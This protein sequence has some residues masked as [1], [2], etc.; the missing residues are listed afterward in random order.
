MRQSSALLL[1]A[2]LS[3]AAAVL[4]AAAAFLLGGQLGGWQWL[5]Y[6]GA[7]VAIF[8]GFYPIRH[9]TWGS[10]RWMRSLLLRQLF[11]GDPAG[12][13]TD[14]P[15]LPGELAAMFEERLRQV[16][17]R[18]RELADRL[19][20]YQQWFEFP[21]PLNLAEVRPA[22]PQTLLRDRALD[23]LLEQKTQL[24]YE[25]I[26]KNEYSLEGTFQFT[27]VRDDVYNLV[28][29]IA[30]LYGNDPRQLLTGVSSERV[31]RAAGRCCVKF[32]VELDKLPLDI[33]TYDVVDVYTYIRRA[34]KVYGLYQSARPYMPWFRSAYYG[35]WLAMGS[36][37]LTM[38][39]WWF[40][41]SLSTRGATTLATNIAN[42]WALNFLHD[43]VRVI[44][45]EVAAIYDR[46]LRYRDPNW[47]FAAELTELVQ[48]FP[49]SEKSLR[50]ALSLVGALQFRNEYDRIFF[51][52]CIVEGK[53]PGLN[54]A[55]AADLLPTQ[56]REI[57]ERLEAFLESYVTAASPKMVQRWRA[58][59]E[60]RLDM[61]L[62]R[63]ESATAGS[64]NQQRRDL[65]RSLAGYL[66]EIKQVEQEAMRPLLERS[67]LVLTMPQPELSDLWQS[68]Q[69]APP[70]FFQT[71]SIVPAE[72]VLRAFVKDLVDLAVS[73]TPRYAVA[74]E[75]VVSTVV[76]LGGDPHTV[77]RLLDGRYVGQL[78]SLLPKDTPNL[79]LP[80]E[81]ARAALDLVQ[82]SEPLRFV[83]GDV[84]PVEVEQSELAGIDRTGTWLVGVGDRL[85]T[86]TL[87]DTPVLLWEGDRRVSVELI[88]GRVRGG[89]HI[90]GGRWLNDEIPSTPVLFLK[91]PFLTSMRRYFAPLQQFC[92]ARSQQPQPGF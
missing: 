51:L 3:I 63:A 86:F 65:I 54:R 30:A 88:K 62:T 4:V 38:G 17:R 52:R 90:S 74:D 47:C 14:L 29:E 58:G 9:A 91:S 40:V 69:D 7:L 55:Q 79:R 28:G 18:E 57:V 80:P 83:Y 60:D 44:G 76:R 53:R 89:C 73:V 16:E 75:I 20:A 82:D 66:L 77:K 49:S 5:F 61:I 45:Y 27:L 19:A 70:F 26:R 2:S 33:H 34:V 68:L 59:L 67:S 36:N 31:L 1:S 6:L 8:G 84:Q 87:G 32:L 15:T 78:A 10:R 81:V 56:R 35:T 13:S 42:R 22:N 25:R 71:P 11:P 24:L 46:N 21:P 23:K 85:V 64:A 12:E 43:I 92:T 72:P 39:A 48:Y 37:P 41:S 50:R